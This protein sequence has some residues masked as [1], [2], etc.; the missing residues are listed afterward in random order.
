[1]L[2]M[3]DFGNSIRKLREDKQLTLKTVAIELQIDIAILSKIERGQ[4]KA[5]REQVLKLAQ[6]YQIEEKDLLILWLSNTLVNQ[7]S[8]EENGLKALKVAEAKVEYD[9]FL[10]I[11]RK[12]LLSQIKAEIKKFS[13]VQKAWIYGSFSREDDSPKSDIDIAIKTDEEFSYFDLAEIQY[14]LEKI[15]NRKIDLGFVDSFK[16]YILDHVKKDLKVIYER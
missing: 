9:A 3:N 7:I 1:M 5:T 16:P 10:K 11:D 12:K 6:Y 2:Q 4:R 14:Q 8:N 13:K 15:S